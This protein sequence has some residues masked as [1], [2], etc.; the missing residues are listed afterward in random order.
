M[1]RKFKEDSNACLAL[2]PARVRRMREYFP[3]ALP[4]HKSEWRVHKK[5]P[6]A[7]NAI[8]KCIYSFT[9]Y[10]KHFYYRMQS[11]EG[12]AHAKILKS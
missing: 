8:L 11:N 2:S 3:V 9:F 10:S 4:H 6:F 12:C 5:F 7:L 1:K